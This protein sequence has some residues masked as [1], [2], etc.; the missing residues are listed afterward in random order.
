MLPENIENASIGF[1]VEKTWISENIDNKSEICLWRYNQTSWNK[2][3]VQRKGED[4]RYYYFEAKTPGFSQFAITACTKEE[5]EYE[6]MKI[7]QKEPEYTSKL[8]KNFW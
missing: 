2:L 7:E 3:E 6:K 1:K 4:D 5:N 8:E